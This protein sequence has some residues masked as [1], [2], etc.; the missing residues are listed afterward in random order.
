IPAITINGL[1]AVTICKGYTTK[2][3]FLKWLLECVLPKINLYLGPR[4]ILVMDNDS[5]HH[6]EKIYEAI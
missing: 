2:E 5:W 3:F 4:P 1:L 6:D